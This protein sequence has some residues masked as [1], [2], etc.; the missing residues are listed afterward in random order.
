MK[1]QVIAHARDVGD[2][3]ADRVEGRLDALA[4]HLLDEAVGLFTRL[5]TCSI[6]L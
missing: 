4:L 5:E 6:G 1:L 3:L 2:R